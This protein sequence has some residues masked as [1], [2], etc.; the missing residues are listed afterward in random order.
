MCVSSLK[1][2]IIE[3]CYDT[4]P[5]TSGNWPLRHVA[6]LESFNSPYMRLCFTPRLFSERAEFS[7]K[8]HDKV[9]VQT[10]RC[11]V[12]LWK[13]CVCKCSIIF[14][15]IK[16]KLLCEALKNEKWKILVWYPNKM[17]RYRQRNPKC[18]DWRWTNF[19]MQVT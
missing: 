16:L 8:L 12:A 9:I 7:L 6:N 3:H 5:L 2:I 10:L 15:V 18:V 17:P 13:S 4:L 14:Q 11:A 19:Q 1:P